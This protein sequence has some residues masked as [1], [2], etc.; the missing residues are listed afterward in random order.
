MRN[1]VSRLQLGIGLVVLLCMG[2]CVQSKGL[3]V[4]RSEAGEQSQSSS[5]AQANP[6]APTVMEV[7]ALTRWSVDAQ[8]LRAVEAHLELFDKFGDTVKGAGRLIAMLRAEGPP[9]STDERQYRWDIDLS[10]PKRATREYYNSTTRTYA[11]SLSLGEEVEAPA[12]ARLTVTLI[13]VEGRRLT[14]EHVLERSG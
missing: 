10:N 1:V 8:G 12:R 7:H 11:I 3:D 6:F 5:T 14:A 13:T 4:R 9:G 2:G